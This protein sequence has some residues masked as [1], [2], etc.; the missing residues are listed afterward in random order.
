MADQRRTLHDQVEQTPEEDIDYLLGLISRFLHL[1]ESSASQQIV[2]EPVPPGSKTADEMKEQRQQVLD[3]LRARRSE[4]ITR[5]M[6]D[7]VTRLGIDL[8]KIGEGSM[9]WSGS[10]GKSEYFTCS[11]FEGPLFNRLSMFRVKERRVVTLERCHI[12][13][14]QPELAYKVRILTPIADVGK[15]LAVPI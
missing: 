11:W 15:E 2:F 5:A 14:T 7:T 1:P 3:R 4:M 12:S 13:K 8:N 6:G 9:S 10:A